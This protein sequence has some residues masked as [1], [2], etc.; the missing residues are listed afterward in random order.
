[1]GARELWQTL[2]ESN[3]IYLDIMAGYI[4]Q[5]LQFSRL[6]YLNECHSDESVPS[7]YMHVHKDIAEKK[8]QMVLALKVR[9]CTHTYTHAH[10]YITHKHA[11]THTYIHTKSA[12][13]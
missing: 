11:H 9:M 4:F 10:T 12:V 6:P 8:I 2:R 5:D 7:Y 1:M 13:L 3:T